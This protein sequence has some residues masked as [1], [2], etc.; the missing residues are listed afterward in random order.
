MEMM[1]NGE[2]IIK[3][4]LFGYDIRAKITRLDI[5]MHILI[6]GGC[7]THIGALGHQDEDGLQIWEF[8]GHREGVIC[9]QWLSECYKAWKMPVTVACGIHYDNLSGEG[10]CRV[11]E[12]SEQMCRECLERIQWGRDF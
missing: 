8:A 11:L 7:R 1:Q 12:R 9:R 5:G 6:T 3:E 10:I 2:W 4:S